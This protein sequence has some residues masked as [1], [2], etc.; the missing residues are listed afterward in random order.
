MLLNTVQQ[1][2]PDT[3]LRLLVLCTGN[4]ARSILAEVLF[5]QLL[6]AHVV[7]FSAGSHPAGRVNPFALELL[8]SQGMTTSALRSKSWQEF[9]GPQAPAL[10]IVLGVCSNATAQCPVF[11]GRYTTVH[12]PLPDPAEATEP[13][14]ARQAFAACWAT[15]AARIAQL[16]TLPLDSISGAELAAHMQALDSVYSPSN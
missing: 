2:S 15:L 6:P 14:Q 1:L 11:P 9:I 5:N 10:D 12:W 8:H 3:R 13:T 7:A 4:S 16:R